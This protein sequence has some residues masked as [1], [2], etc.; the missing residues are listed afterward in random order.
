MERSAIRDPHPRAHFN[1]PC[2]SGFFLARH[3]VSAKA[4]AGELGRA[5]QGGAPELAGF[6]ARA[7]QRAS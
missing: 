7:R 6:K 3:G 2:L 1:A 4:R 5:N